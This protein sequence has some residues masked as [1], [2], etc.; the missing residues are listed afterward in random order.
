MLDIKF[1][2]ENKDLVKENCKN[3][4][5][6]LDVDELLKLD[7]QRRASQQ[8]VEALRAQRKGQSK[9]KPSEED[10]A[11]LR[12][13]GD[14][15]S[16]LEKAMEEVENKYRELLLRVPN[17]THPESPIGGEEDYKVVV[18]KG[19]V[20]EFSF[21]QGR[22]VAM[23]FRPDENIQNAGGI[24]LDKVSLITFCLED[25][26]NKGEVGQSLHKILDGQDRQNPPYTQAGSQGKNPYVIAGYMPFKDRFLFVVGAETDGDIVNPG[27]ADL[28]GLC[29]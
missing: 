22:S 16:A 21:P 6:S 9:G 10:I 8:E 23:D 26:E 13:M 17:L 24:S 19:K 2:R 15:I 18:K 20:P 4:H 28:N 5:V 25:W 3:R 1:I 12:K 7:E 11:R 14:E 27:Y 29:D